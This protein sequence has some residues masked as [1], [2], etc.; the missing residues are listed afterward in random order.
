VSRMNI[1]RDEQAITTAQATAQTL[2]TL[3]TTAMANWST[4]LRFTVLCIALTM[5]TAVGLA[6]Y[7]LLR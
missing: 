4:T 1:R 3:I 5:P 2:S 7:L 6:L